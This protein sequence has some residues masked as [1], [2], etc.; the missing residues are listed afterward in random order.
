MAH[1]AV[2]IVNYN[3]AEL[4]MAGVASVLDPA[5]SHGRHQVSVHLVDNASPNG[6][7]AQFRAAAPGWG[8]RVTLY[9]E[10]TNHGFGRGNN[11]VL[12]RLTQD[13]NP[14][15]YVFLLN[16]DAQ[17]KN[18]TLAVLSAHLEAHPKCAIAGAR[19]FNPDADDPV[20]AAFQFPG[21]TS[22]F[23]AAL[24]LGP[25]A[26]LLR[27]YDLPIDAS[28]PSQQVDWVSGAAV[29]AR[30]EVWRDLGFFDPEYFLYYEEVD[31][32]LQ[33]ARAGW[34]CWHVTEAE[35]V[36]VEG[37][38]TDVRSAN[39]GRTRRP[40]YWYHSWQYYFRKNYGRP[41]ALLAALV[42][43]IGATGN[44]VHAS[45]RREPVFTPASFFKDFWAA[46]LRPLLAFRPRP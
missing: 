10:D 11:L 15:D 23:S 39:A 4:V 44:L 33:T 17:L 18:D 16:P 41:Y 34:D 22:T 19:A 20:V 2:I 3:A 32:M 31:L 42:W 21:L 26:R 35:I 29:L 13:P 8:E 40:L 5:R 14:P 28:L 24:N 9:L 12:N 25:V 6:D 43:I 7:A 45:L 30:F 36:H 38:S 46:G 1:N 27:R 37:A